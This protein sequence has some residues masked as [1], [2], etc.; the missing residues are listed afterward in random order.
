MITPNIFQ[1]GRTEQ[2]DH[3]D[4]IDAYSGKAGLLCRCILFGL[5]EPPTEMDQML[6]LV[7]A[8]TIVEEL[9]QTGKQNFL[10]RFPRALNWALRSE[11]GP[12]FAV[13]TIEKAIAA[14]SSAQQAR[15]RKMPEYKAYSEKFA[16]VLEAVYA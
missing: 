6:Q 13:F 14:R 11:V 16:G 2:L 12:E 9:G 10:T 7:L 15:V 4:L 1:I 3:Q 5:V 8:E